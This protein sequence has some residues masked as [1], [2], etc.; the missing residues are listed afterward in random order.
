MRTGLFL[1]LFLPGC[2]PPV[3]EAPSPPHGVVINE[4]QAD[5]ATTLAD[6]VGGFDDWVELFNPGAEVADLTGHYLTDNLGDPLRWRFPSGTLVEPGGYLLVW[7]DGE[8]DGSL[9]ASFKL[10]SAGE[11]IGLFGPVGGEIVMLDAGEFDEQD[12]DQSMARTPDGALNWVA[13][14]SPTPG[15]AND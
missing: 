11:E 1:L 4:L 12:Q 7:A 6:E 9:H 8:P 2:L 15:T 14:P 13:D 5:N 10:S 3:G